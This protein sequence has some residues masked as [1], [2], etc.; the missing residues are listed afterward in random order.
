MRR[1]ASG[2]WMGDFPFPHNLAGMTHSG[3]MNSPE[4]VDAKWLGEG[5]RDL[6]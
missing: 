3:K 4:E 2:R 6:V 1:D 5:Q